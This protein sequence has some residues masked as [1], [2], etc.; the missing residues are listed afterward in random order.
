M[1]PKSITNPNNAIS[2]MKRI[3]TQHCS[4]L[5]PYSPAVESLNNMLLPYF[6][7]CHSGMKERSILHHAILYDLGVYRGYE[8]DPFLPSF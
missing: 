2:V 8:E 6:I 5:K 1:K 7:G 3:Q 4:S